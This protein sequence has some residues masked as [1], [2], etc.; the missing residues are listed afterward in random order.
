M[1][2]NAVYQKPGDLADVIPVVIVYRKR[3]RRRRGL[4]SQLLRGL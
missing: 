1:P 2:M 4:L 3:G